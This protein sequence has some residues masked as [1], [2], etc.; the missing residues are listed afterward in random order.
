MSVSGCDAVQQRP[1]PAG[2][3]ITPHGPGTTG[4]P[5]G[6]RF[7]LASLSHWTVL[8]KE[9]DSDWLGRCIGEV[10]AMTGVMAGVCSGLFER[11]VQTLC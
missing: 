10:R 9:S 3:R 8:A 1:L 11:V 2:R 4:S 6:A 5:S 7:S